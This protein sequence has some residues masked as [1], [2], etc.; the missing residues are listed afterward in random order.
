MDAPLYNRSELWKS[1]VEIRENDIRKSCFDN[2]EQETKAMI[3]YHH[4]V[5]FWGIVLMQIVRVLM[6]STDVFYLGLKGLG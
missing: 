1:A 4:E 6:T 2:C 5:T 3:T